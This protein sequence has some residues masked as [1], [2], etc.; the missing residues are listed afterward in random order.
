MDTDAR[1]DPRTRLL[2]AG[3]VLLAAALGVNSLLGPLGSETIRYR[4]SESLINQG[5]GLDAVAL[6]GAVPIALAAAALVARGHRGGPVLAFIP[7]TFAVYMVPQYVVGPEYLDLPGN[8]ERFFLFHVLL[9][10]LALALLV[11]TWSCVDRSSLR[12]ASES[13]DR[14]RSLVMFGVAAF[15][16]LG[17]WLPGIIELSRGEPAS[18][19]FLENP[20]AY[21]L[22]GVLDL[23]L[24][25]PAAVAAGIALRRG[26]AWAREASYAVIGWFALVPAAVAAMAITMEVN[27][28]PNATTA[29][30]ALFA[31]AA[32]VFTVG[33]AALYVPMFG[34]DDV[35]SRASPDGPGAGEDDR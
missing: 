10:V 19:D 5:I 33:A 12:P 28:D 34:R 17:R 4:Y 22:I 18:V 26:V 2:S 29:A 35:G 8:N 16:L 3:L 7:T 1:S 15:V 13:S 23:G 27:D 24:V 11:T 25:V 14:R 30:T 32:V 20:T 31:T 6:L 21:M 9:F